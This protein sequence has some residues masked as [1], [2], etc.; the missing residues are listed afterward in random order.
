MGQSIYWKENA[1]VTLLNKC[2]G[3]RP[4]FILSRMNLYSCKSDEKKLLFRPVILF[5][6]FVIS[7][8]LNCFVELMSFKY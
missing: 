4:F 3:N 5:P 1:I 2:Q 8:V 7:T 6:T